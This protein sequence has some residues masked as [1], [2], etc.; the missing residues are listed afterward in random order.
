L[1]RKV[2]GI[3][4]VLLFTGMLTLSF[5]I[6]LVKAATITVPNDYPTIQA[7]I[8]AASDGDTVF[9]RN[10]DYH[11]IVIANKT[12]SLIGEDP[13]STAINGVS[14]TADDVQVSGFHVTLGGTG[15]YI[16]Y[17]D[18]TVVMNNQIDYNGGGI[19]IDFANQ[20]TV[21]NNLIDHNGGSGIRLY[22]SFNN[23]VVGNTISNTTATRSSAPFR[24]TYSNDSLIYHNNFIHNI[25][26]PL[27]IV[28]SFNKWDDGYPI[29]GN[30]WGPWTYPN[31]VF[32]GPYQNETG[33]DGIID[34][35]FWHEGIV[36]NYPLAKPWPWASHDLG[37]TYIGS[38]TQKTVVPQGFKLTISV[39]VMNYGDNS[40]ILNVSTYVNNTVIGETTNYALANEDSTTL[41]ITWDTKGFAMGNYT[42][43]AYVQPVLGETDMSDNNLA[44]GWMTLT[45]PGD[46]NGDLNV[47]LADLVILANAYG[48]N[49]SLGIAGTG[50]H[51][52]NPNADIDGNYI[53]GLSD[54]VILAQHYRQHYP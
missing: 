46:L 14:V 51:E 34:G 36:D 1:E 17:A 54:L 41:N 19:V 11:E 30:Y 38:S 35:Y 7:A 16:N 42:M 37:L 4:L 39:Y 15:V 47:S 53:V 27:S 8:N 48:T 26:A 43:S 20:T 49:A 50:L 9:V 10:G 2:S 40:E 52:Y 12:I 32:K 25:W 24:A 21:L 3:L 33:S 5:K 13:H 29:G 18:R 6:Q 28:Q 22:S 45:I 31:D 44:E 23:T